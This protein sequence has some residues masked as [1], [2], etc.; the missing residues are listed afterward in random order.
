M[1]GM[2][3]KRLSLGPDHVNDKPAILFKHGSGTRVAGN[4]KKI[5]GIFTF[6]L[7]RT[8][9]VSPAR[10]L[11]RLR[12]KVARV[13]R[14]VSMRRKSSRKVTSSSFPRSRSV[15]AAVDSQRAEAIE[16]CIEFLNSSSSL[17]RDGQFGIIWTFNS[18]R[19]FESRKNVC[20]EAR[21]LGM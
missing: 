8:S 2:A 13:I 3:S 11:K 4:R 6:R 15:V 12:A 16:D 1:S 19:A 21:F 18:G 9:K 20:S 5:A 14:F 17:H 10:L 7:P